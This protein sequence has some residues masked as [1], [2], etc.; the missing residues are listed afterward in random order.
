MFASEM[1]ANNDS[2]HEMSSMDVLYKGTLSTIRTRPPPFLP[3]LTPLGGI[4]LRPKVTKT[5]LP[6]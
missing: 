4:V 1:V 6:T 2:V 3:P 5:F